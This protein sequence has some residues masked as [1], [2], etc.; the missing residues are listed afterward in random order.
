M[1]T[2]MKWMEIELLNSISLKRQEMIQVGQEKGLT[3]E[4][5]LQVSQ[6]L[7]EIIVKYQT[8]KKRSFFAIA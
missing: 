1:S 3:S 6:E 7:D 4:E 5:T 2:A 8:I